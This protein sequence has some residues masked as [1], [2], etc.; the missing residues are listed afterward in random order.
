MHRGSAPSLSANPPKFAP[1]TRHEQ[2][3]PISGPLYTNE[4]RDSV[5]ADKTMDNSPK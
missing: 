1:A 4:V 2:A 5:T 3:L